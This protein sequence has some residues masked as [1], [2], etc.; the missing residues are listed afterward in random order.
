MKYKH[1]APKAEVTVAR[2][3]FADFLLALAAGGY[4]RA[5]LFD[6]EDG[7]CPV[8]AVFLGD[9]NDPLTQTRR[10]FDALRE[11]DKA[12]AKR[13]LSRAPEETGVGLGVCNRL[14]RAAA[15][16]FAET[17]ERGRIL[18][19]CGPTGAGKSYV[20]GLLAKE[21]FA[22]VDADKVARE[23]VKPGSDLLL[24][25]ANAFGHDIIKEDGSLDRRRLAERA[26]VNKDTAARL[27]ALT[28]PAI[29]QRMV[30]DALAF[31][32]TG[33]SVVLD[34]PLLYSAKLDRLC[35]K[36]IK[37]TAPEEIRKARIMSR[38]GITGKDAGKRMAAQTEEDEASNAADLILVNDGR[39]IETELRRFLGN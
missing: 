20:T 27:S 19:V 21:G 5:L 4:D 28:H 3:T 12:G 31:V 32:K 13:V 15:F 30:N 35:D 22:V 23:V 33:R 17:P 38:D 2:G 25:L 39:E 26:F 24:P 11:L 18:G 8:P 9:K 1:Y 7:L 29:V 34:A 36:V 37:V 6:G 14:Y 16:R 10:L